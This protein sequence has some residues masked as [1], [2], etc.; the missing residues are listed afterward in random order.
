MDK[1]ICHNHKHSKIIGQV[2]A[3]RMPAQILPQRVVLHNHIGKTPQKCSQKT[4]WEYFSPA[5]FVSK[6]KPDNPAYNKNNKVKQLTGTPEGIL[7]V[8]TE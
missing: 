7:L 2:Y 6:H 5:F 3:R 1:Q 4:H 8:H